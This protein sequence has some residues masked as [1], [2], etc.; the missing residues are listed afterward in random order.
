MDVRMARL[1]FGVFFLLAFSW[2]TTDAAIAGEAVLVEVDARETTGENDQFWA[3]LVFHPTEYL[4]TPWG[5][6]HIAL[7]RESGAALNFVRIYNQPEDAAYLRDDGSVGYDWDHF[8][9][10][11]DLILEQGVKP[12]V[13]FF[14]MP[15]QIAADPEL[16]RERPFLDGKPIY[17]GLPE[18]F[19]QW[20]DMVVDFT[21]HV[22]D[23][24]GEDEVADWV[25]MCW[26]EPDL[27]S[28]SQF[29][30]EEYYPLYDYFAEGVRSVSDRIRIGGPSLSS[31]KTFREPENFEGFASHVAQGTNYATGETGSPIDFLTIHTYGG[32]GASGGPLSD[33]PCVDYMLEQQRR[34]VAIRDEFPELRDTSVYVAEWGV[35]A[36]GGRGMD[37][38]PMAEVRNSQYSPAFMTTAVTRLHDLRRNEGFPVDMLAICF[39][40]YEIERSSDFEG[41][42]T[43]S[44]LNDFDKPLLNGYRMLARL[45]DE[46]VTRRV[47]PEDAPVTALAARDGEDRIGVLVTHFQNHHTQNDGPPK[48][49][50]LEILTGWEDGAAVEAQHWRVDETHS[51][52]YTLF[53][54]MGRPDP[55]TEEQIEQI[56]A[57]M[58][59]EALE[60]PRVT[61]LD[62]AFTMDFELPCNA[63]SLIEITRKN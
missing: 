59:L 58:G 22:I 11:A 23:R 3:S 45:G 32:H 49:I 4:S 10:R 28:F 52:A 57:R 56:Q 9:R 17:L 50:S 42:R 48:P 7:L 33:Y 47:S 60:E 36:S 39:S 35:S 27:G 26:N 43:A 44:T 12:A 24:Y 46:W 13:A 29:E 16:L 20:R 51:N 63:I 30:V 19:D 40:G 55:P 6:E 18:D 1:L 34:L 62:G 15:P 61:Q 31:G 21:Q 38:E 37:R 53:R 54:E 2:L 8:D 14:S 5:E 25:F 41:K